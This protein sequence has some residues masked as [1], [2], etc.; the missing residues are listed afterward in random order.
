MTCFRI[1]SRGKSSRVP[2]K[3]RID[4]DWI[5]ENES[6]YRLQQLGRGACGKT[7]LWQLPGHSDP[8]CLKNI[9][10]PDTRYND[11]IQ[12]TSFLIKLQ[13]AGG[14]PRIHG[15]APEIG[16][17]FMDYISGCEL[18]A[19][20]SQNEKKYDDFFWIQVLEKIIHNIQQVHKKN[21][22][23]MD[24]KQNNV[25]V[26][27]SDTSNPKVAIIDY[28][29]GCKVGQRWQ[30]ADQTAKTIDKFMERFPWYSYEAAMGLP[31]TAKSDVYAVSSMINQIIDLMDR[32]PSQLITL[33]EQGLSRDAKARP[34]FRHFQKVIKKIKVQWQK[35]F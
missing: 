13:G 3:F 12:E 24:L 23:H 27:A 31:V 2:K 17:Y 25:M 35:K 1:F 34:S 11:T 28:G 9:F 26:D 6:R 19:L 32:K 16:C 10:D 15:V 8:V 4:P 5:I 30:F 29:L 20:T 33:A 7:Q 22:V 14:A 18:Y 21:V